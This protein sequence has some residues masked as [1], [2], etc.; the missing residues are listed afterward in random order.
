M[1]QKYR[2][3]LPVPSSDNTSS[4]SQPS[5]SPSTLLSFEKLPKRQRIG[6]QLACN[7]C[8]RR[9]VRVSEASSHDPLCPP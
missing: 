4:Q 5:G 6:T 8:R 3:L 9:K 2:H 7:E 1:S